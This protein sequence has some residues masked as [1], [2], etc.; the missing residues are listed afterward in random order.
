M[1]FNIGGTQYGLSILSNRGNDR[2]VAIM[3]GG[4]VREFVYKKERVRCRPLT[5]RTKRG[6]S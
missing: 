4:L 6:Q 2:D 5:G 1:I 3:A